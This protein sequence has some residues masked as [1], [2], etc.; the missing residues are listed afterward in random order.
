MT[1]ITPF[2][3]DSSNIQNFQILT[4]FW[5][6]FEIFW[7]NQGHLVN[8]HLLSP[9]QG[10][11]FSSLQSHVEFL[12]YETLEFLTQYFIVQLFDRSFFTIVWIFEFPQKVLIGSVIMILKFFNSGPGVHGF[13]PWIKAVSVLASKKVWC[14]CDIYNVRL[15]PCPPNVGLFRFFYVNR[16]K[17]NGP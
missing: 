2:N 14:P 1:L 16:R 4:D 5:A 11:Q 8:F 7:L 17:L 3:R 15:C 9:S 12:K 13:K 10:C 6:I